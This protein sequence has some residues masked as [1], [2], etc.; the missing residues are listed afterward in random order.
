[1]RLSDSNKDSDRKTFYVTTPIYYPSGIPHL[2]TCY[3]TVAADVLA[4][5]KRLQGY[6]V[7][8]TTGVDEHGQ[9]IENTAKKQ[10]LLPKELCDKLALNFEELWREFDISYNKFI[11]TTDDYHK[12][13]VQKIFR[14]LFER[15]QIYKGKYEGW[16]CEPCEA[17]FTK[18]QL[19]DG[20]CPDCGREVKL[21]C[22]E[23]YFFKLSEYQEKLLKFYD[24]SP[25][26]LGPERCKREVVQFVK[27]GLNDLCVS[28][29]EMSWGVPVDFDDEHVVY[30]WIDALS[31]Y[32]T[33]LGYGTEN[34]ANFKKFWPADVHI[35]GKDIVRFH[36]VIW[37]AI[38][39]AL[40]LPLP[41]RIFAHGWLLSGEKN[42]KM[43]KSKGNV[44]NPIDLC[45]KY[46]VDSLRYFL[47]REFSFG[48]DGTYSEET[49][50]NR[51][52]SDLANSFGNLVSRTTAMWE[53][54]FPDGFFVEVVECEEDK[55][56]I[57]MAEVLPEEY[58]IQ[59]NNLKFSV[60][61][62]EVWK[63]I[64]KCNSYIDENEP[65]NLAKKIENR[66]RL[67]CVL[68]NVCE[69]LR[70]VSILISPFMPRTFEVIS[71]IFGMAAEEKNWLTTK[72]FGVLHKNLNLKKC[73]SIF[74][75]IE[76]IKND[77]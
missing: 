74:P 32:I 61:L 39:M 54:Y 60:A 19:C 62:E 73:K 58:E 51:I 5:F 72:K 77:F 47:M 8:F 30:V 31:N 16:Y 17:Y 66:R 9:K 76:V 20:K 3:S 36:G 33:S 46:D 4:R 55:A 15:G 42:E 37:P 11:R 49:L 14:G 21:H 75:R 56:L 67:A 23:S 53:K 63:F 45:N 29:S 38:L 70:I 6:E 59:M 35:L 65:W 10:G 68:Y 2:G 34:D 24:E 69:S 52:N 13:A 48:S 28:R 1:M 40:D 25:D 18:T 22:E 43:S 57:N 26:F 71:S 44:V 27:M 41:K 64:A 12:T 7:M 50:I